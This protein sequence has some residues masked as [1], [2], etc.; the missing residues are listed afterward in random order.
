MRIQIEPVDLKGDVVL[1]VRNTGSEVLIG[2]GVLGGAETTEPPYSLYS[3][4]SAMGPYRL[5]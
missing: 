3:T 2:I 5:L 4:G 1:G